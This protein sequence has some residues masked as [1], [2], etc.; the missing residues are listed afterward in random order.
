MEKTGE[1]IIQYFSAFALNICVL[2]E[3]YCISPRNFAVI[4]KTF[5]FCYF[6]ENL[7]VHQQNIY[8]LSQSAAFPS[9][10]FFFFAFA[11]K[12]IAVFCKTIVFSEETL[13]SFTK[14][15]KYSFSSHLIL[16]PSQKLCKRA[17]KICKQTNV[18]RANRVSRGNAKAVKYNFSFYL[19]FF[20]NHHIPFGRGGT[21]N[22]CIAN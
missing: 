6:P 18:L 14:A 12:K 19:I 2:S 15:M 16:F 3:K 1:K 22:R 4:H 20:P 8:V 7:G 21:I 10:T 5:A 9:E 17:Q 11:R 13:R